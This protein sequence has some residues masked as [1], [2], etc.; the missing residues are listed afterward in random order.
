MPNDDHTRL[1]SYCITTSINNRN[2]LTD[3]N[4]ATG[5]CKAQLGNHTYIKFDQPRGLVVRVFDY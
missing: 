3:H 2:R 4:E 1:L 5:L